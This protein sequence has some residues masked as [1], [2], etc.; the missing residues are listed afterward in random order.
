MKVDSQNV[1]GFAIPV[2]AIIC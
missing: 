2:H 1:N